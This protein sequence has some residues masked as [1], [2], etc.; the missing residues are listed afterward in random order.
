MTKEKI[1]IKEGDLIRIPIDSHR[2]GIA[3]VMKMPNKHSFMIRIFDEI[4]T[5]YPDIISSNVL[6][7]GI[8]MDAKIFHG[9]WELIKK[10]IDIRTK[11]LVPFYKIGLSLDNAFVVDYSGNIIRKCTVEDFAFLDYMTVVAPVRFE[12]ALRAHFGIG[13]WKPEYT[14]IRLK[15][16]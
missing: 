7:L 3:E 1:L 12:L 16:R 4:Y 13:D 11:T 15:S 14:S 6:L 5:D 10:P 2:F 9:D 8:T